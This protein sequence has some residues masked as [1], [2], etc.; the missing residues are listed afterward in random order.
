MVNP[1]KSRLNSCPNAS[2]RLIRKSYSGSASKK[3]AWLNVVLY[4]LYSDSI[5]SSFKALKF[6]DQANIIE[7]IVFDA[8]T[9]ITMQ[10]LTGF[11]PKAGVCLN[12]SLSVICL[13]ISEMHSCVKALPA[14]TAP[15]SS[16]GSLRILVNEMLFKGDGKEKQPGSSLLSGPAWVSK[17]R[18][19]DSQFSRPTTR[20]HIW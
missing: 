6:N 14:I 7:F 18:C 9:L 4:K 2:L 10:V 17:H 8:Q 20:A 12:C 3:G 15:A 16:P 5:G 13:L 19:L 11:R 1:D